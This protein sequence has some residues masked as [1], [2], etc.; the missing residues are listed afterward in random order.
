MVTLLDRQIAPLSLSAVCSS[1]TKQTP[2]MRRLM[3][4]WTGNKLAPPVG[5]ANGRCA[6]ARGTSG[7]AE[8]A[9]LLRPAQR[10]PGMGEQLFSGQ[11]ARL[12]AVEDRPGDVWCQVAQ[13]HQP[14][15]VGAA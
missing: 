7:E 9:A 3:Q 8:H 1:T 14:G 6:G 10:Q 12:A 15:V 5:G 11:V 13:A 4:S 2:V